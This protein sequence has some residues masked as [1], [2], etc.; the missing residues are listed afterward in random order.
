M[1]S[2]PKFSVTLINHPQYLINSN[3]QR[4]SLLTT[5]LVVYST[6]L[7][8]KYV[9][10]CKEIGTGALEESKLEAVDGLDRTTETGS[11]K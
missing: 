1:Y 4:T 11:P 9:Q 8:P 10:H 5:S 3:D 6:A 7:G 2:H